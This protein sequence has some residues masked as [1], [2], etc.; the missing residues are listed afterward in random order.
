MGIMIA[1]TVGFG[2][3]EGKDWIKASRLSLLFKG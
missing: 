3:I 1:E 2:K